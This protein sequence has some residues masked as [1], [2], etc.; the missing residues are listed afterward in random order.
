MHNNAESCSRFTCFGVFKQF[1]PDVGGFFFFLILHVISTSVWRLSVICCC[2]D[3]QRSQ[4]ICAEPV[5]CVSASFWISE[6]LWGNFFL[7]SSLYCW[8]TADCVCVLPLLRRSVCCLHNFEFRRS[9]HVAITS[10]LWDLLTSH[11]DLADASLFVDTNRKW[12]SL[13]WEKGKC[14]LRES[15]PVWCV[16]YTRTNLYKWGLFVLIG[17]IF[18]LGTLCLFLGFFYFHSICML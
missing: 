2:C 1:Q 6:Q 17:L 16:F 3:F 13:V 9:F 14:S 18:P 7:L 15:E 12:D 11:F 5:L 4:E 10:L 8:C